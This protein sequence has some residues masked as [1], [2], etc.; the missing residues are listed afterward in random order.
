LNPSGTGPYKF[1]KMVPHQRLE[2]V[3]NTEYWIKRSAEAGPPRPD[4][5]AGSSTRTAVADG[6]VGWIE[7]PSPMRSS[8]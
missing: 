4:P 7:A 1:D 6:Q 8:G 2:F 5:D 3:A